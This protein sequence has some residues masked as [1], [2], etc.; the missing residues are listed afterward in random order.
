[1]SNVP[2]AIDIVV[3][4]RLSQMRF[5]KTVQAVIETLVNADT[6]EYKVKYDGNI[7]SAFATDLTNTY[8]RGQSVFVKIP[9]NDFSNKKFI[10]S[11]V[12]SQ[13][14]S[15]QKVNEQQ[16]QL[17]PISPSLEVFY[18][19][20]AAKE[21]GIIASPN[22]SL[23]IYN[24]ENSSPNDAPFIQYA[25]NYNLLQ[26]KA[27]FRTEL[28]SSHTKG[29]Y[30]L[31]FSF[32]TNEGNNT[33]YQFDISNF[34]GA[35]YKFFDASEQS[36]IL[37]VPVKYLIGLSKITFFCD[38]FNYDVLGGAENRNTPNLFVSNIETRFIE[39]KEI[40]HNETY[41]Q[42]ETLDGCV[43]TD[44]TSPLSL[45]ALLVSNGYSV[46]N[47]NADICT[48][49]GSDYSV[50]LGD[51]NY[52]KDVGPGWIKVS[53]ENNVMY[54]V[55]NPGIDSKY[56]NRFYK[57][58]ITHNGKTYV[59]DAVEIVQSND[60]RK[61]FLVKEDRDGSTFLRIADPAYKGKWYCE[62]PDK[63]YKAV[64]ADKVNEID[65]KPYLTYD[66]AKFYCEVYYNDGSIA[67]L[68]YTSVLS[69]SEDDLKISFEGESSFIYNSDGTIDNKISSIEHTLIPQIEWKEGKGTSYKIKFLGPDGKELTD[70]GYSPSN[71]MMQDIY[72]DSNYVVH[73]KILRSFKSKNNQNSITLVLTTIDGTEY[74]LIKKID[75]AQSGEQGTSG[76]KY[77]IRVVPIDAA[78]QELEYDTLVFGDAADFIKLKVIV[79]KS[80]MQVDESD[81]DVTWLQS[82]DLQIAD[83]NVTIK[84]DVTEEQIKKGSWVKASA[85]I[86][87]DNLTISVYYP[88]DIIV[89][90][91]TNKEDYS[92]S[93]DSFTSY[94]KYTSNGLYPSYTKD[95]AVK[96]NDVALGVSSFASLNTQ[97]KSKVSTTTDGEIQ[98]VP[99]FKFNGSYAEEPNTY[100][101]V[102]PVECQ[103][104]KNE[105][106]LYHSI[107]YYL[108]TYGNEDINGWDGT[109]LK[110]NE[111]D[112][113]TVFAPT[114]G[115]GTKDKENKFSG[116]VM[117]QYKDSKGSKTGLYGFGA[118][119]NT[120]GLNADGTAYFGAPD[121]GRITIGTDGKA[122][123]SGGLGTSENNIMKLR[124][125]GDSPE[126]KA[127]EVGTAFSVNYKG[128]LT[129]TNATITGVITATSGTMNSVD[130]NSGTIGGWTIDSDSIKAGNTTLNKSG[131]I[132]TNY[133]QAGTIGQVGIYKSKSPGVGNILGIT[134]TSN[135]A[136]EA[137]NG[138]IRLTASSGAEGQILLQ[139]NE[140]KFEGNMVTGITATFA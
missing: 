113:Q 133:F 111:D 91:R 19:Y 62:L 20:D 137:V 140:L 118:G 84:A 112:G 119:V 41:I 67:Y 121:N 10:E 100:F 86:K 53:T 54:S 56:F 8:R 2:Q 127:I 115:A 29:N 68:S 60:E 130:I 42:I 44:T 35:P 77:L 79:T 18:K 23:D 95:V 88:I 126:D 105:L 117:G 131:I 80:G 22:D 5:D 28:Y 51:E 90:K 97:L 102:D 76:T 46:L 65:I 15:S 21:Y 32:L 45:K 81:Y 49:Y 109:S 96:Y 116:V 93:F 89:D 101:F 64:S 135:M 59:S 70:K 72:C 58:V 43:F 75:F 24:R 132:T 128:E 78:G 123:I 37:T 26:I 73:Y 83:K 104:V 1:M 14:L 108:D 124:L 138:T 36:V 129:A 34:N 99:P 52:N 3:N 39:K 122:V 40:S 107:I 69:N 30:G 50:M 114:V 63:S 11:Q 110:I 25:N 9:E 125:T 71:S 66:Y 61:L 38:N 94:V 47:A 27:K 33:E 134:S 16:N 98:Y 55:P 4:H 48:W 85:N 12:G 17:L 74:T 103:L 120:F 87:S 139:A 106:I 136:L 92:L 6:G 31:K 13:S 57:A 7:F 82:D